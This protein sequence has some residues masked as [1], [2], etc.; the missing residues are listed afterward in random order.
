MALLEDHCGSRRSLMQRGALQRRKC[1]WHL[2]FA[3]IYTRSAPLGSQS[4]VNRFRRNR[5]S[6]VINIIPRNES[7][8]PEIRSFPSRSF[9]SVRGFPIRSEQP[10]M[11][12]ELLMTKHSCK[13]LIVKI[14]LFMELL[15]GRSTGNREKGGSPGGPYLEGPVFMMFGKNKHTKSDQRRIR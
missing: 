3:L 1:D 15:Q 14:I 5:S 8:S 4:G 2:C 7:R 10:F 11:T 6:P 13:G 12:V 9:V